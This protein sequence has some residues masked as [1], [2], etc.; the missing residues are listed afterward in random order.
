MYKLQISIG[1]AM[2]NK[3]KRLLEPDIKAMVLNHLISKER[4]TPNTS[5]INE[6]TIGNYSRRVDL[7]IVNEKH[8]VAFEIKSEADTLNRLSGQTNKYLEYFDKVIIVA[9]TKHIK[10]IVETV[11]KNVAVWEVINK[12]IKI[13]QRGKIVPIVNRARLIDLMKANELLKLSHRLNLTPVS[14]KR[15]S[16]VSAVLKASVPE[17]REASLRCLKDRYY[18]TSSLLFKKIEGNQVFPEDIDLLSPYRRKRQSIIALNKERETLWQV[19]EK[20]IEDQHLI[21][22][23]QSKRKQI[24]GTVPVEISNLI[25]A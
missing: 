25:T 12:Q 7:A 17:L 10:K 13:R 11:P 8:L 3:N 4:I 9:A 14:K 1:T 23:S 24:F 19:W 5:I 20:C 6:F 21:M 2:T 22:M 15:A 18:N 16:L